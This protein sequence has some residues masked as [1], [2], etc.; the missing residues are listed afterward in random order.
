MIETLRQ[1]LRAGGMAILVFIATSPAALAGDLPRAEAP[2]NQGIVELETGNAAGTSVRIAEEIAAAVDDGATL[3][4]LPVIG[5]GA[6]QNLSDLQLL[7]GIDVAI[8]QSDVL[9][10]VRRQRPP[11]LENSI[12][13]I[14]KLYN[15]EFHLLA[16]SDIRGVADLAHQTIDVGRRGSG[17][18]VTAAQI[19]GA[20]GI[21]I[22]ITYDEEPVALEKLKEGDIAALAFVAAMPAPLLGG[23]KAGAGLHLL[24]VPFAAKFA[25]DYMPAE[26]TAADYP[27]LV[28][29]G[30]PVDT[31]AVAAVLAVGNVQPRSE[32]YRNI[33]H[34][35][36]ALFAGFPALLEP[37]HDP[38]WREVSLAADIPGWHRF[39]P[40]AAWLKRNAAASSLD[41]AARKQLFERFIAARF[42]AANV[43]AI[44]EPED[45]VSGSPRR[46]RGQAH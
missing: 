8:I 36:D 35:V 37:G 7:H 39:P 11:G 16:R 5:E 10:Y 9:D 4:V 31:V 12:T 15:E 27:N 17:A 40:A 25:T 34:F 20:L 43:A 18:S 28:A 23:I 30:R 22:T 24:S 21:P 14:A 2:N 44:A 19:F 6:L 1:S 32:R 13:Y 38:A 29:T 3:R 33:A 26:F 41:A 46:H 42:P 45:G